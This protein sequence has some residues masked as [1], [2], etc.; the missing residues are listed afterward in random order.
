VIAGA[1]GRPRGFLALL[2]GLI[3]LAWLTLFLWELS[4]YARYLDHGKWT[5]LG[6]G[7]WLCRAVP[8]GSLVVPMVLYALAW[9]LMIAAMMLPTILPLLGMFG[10]VTEDRSDRG[11]LL[12]LL[13]AGY[14]LVWL[15]FGLAAHAVDYGLHGLAAW[16]PWFSFNGWLVGAGVLVIAGAFQFSRMKYACLDKCRAPFSF[17]NQ[18]WRGTTPY[19]QSFRLGLHHGLFCVGCCWAIMLL[20]FVVGTASV[21][22]MLALGAVMAIEKNVAWG[23]KLSAPL[24]VA[25]FGWATF[26]VVGHWAQSL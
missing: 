17:V 19:R 12:L 13:I 24:G 1:L 18:H 6:L 7:G 5:E 9:V 4:P 14:L 26:I 23:R 21:S 25:L 11:T 2:G 20:M 15:A 22:W 10:R 3:A 8:A 16:F